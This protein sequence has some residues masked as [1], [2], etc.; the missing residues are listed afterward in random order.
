[1]AATYEPIAS[2]TLGTATSSVSFTSIAADW[3]DLILIFQQTASSNEG[4]L[5]R[6]NGD[7]GSNYSNTRLYGDGS[8]ATSERY[9]N[10]TADNAGVA[11]SSYITNGRLQIMSYANTSVYKTVLIEANTPQELLMRS[12][13]LWRSTS[14]VTSITI[15]P[16]G[17]ATWSSG[18]TFSLYGIKAA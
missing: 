12:V 3:T 1:M 2:T 13:G 4:A 18:S 7:T 5:F 17:G 10:Q 8:S 15:L 14:A 9:S 11:R 6:L 16:G